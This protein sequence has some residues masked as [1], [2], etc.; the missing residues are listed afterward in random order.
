MLRPAPRSADHRDMRSALVIGTVLCA[1]ALAGPALAAPARVTPSPSVAALQVALRAQGHYV[2]PIDG[3]DGP[4]TQAALQSLRA[5]LGLARET[6]LGPRTRAA[7]GALGKPL[8]GQR[9]LLPGA[10]GWDV[11]SLEFQ[12]RPFGLPAREIDGRFTPA[13]AA[14]LRRFQAARGLAPDGIAG[15]RTFR[16][17]AT[18]AGAAA[19]KPSVRAVH[20]VAAGESFFSI[21]QRFAVSPLLLATENGLSLSSVILPGQRLRP[22]GREQGA[23]DGRPVAGVGA[24]RAARRPGCGQG[25]PRPL[26]GRLWRRP[27]P[28]PRGRV[29]GVGL[30]GGRGLG[31]RRDRRDA[32]P[33][34]RRGR[35]STRLIGV[36]TPRTYDGNVR[37]GRALPALAARRVRRR[38]PARP[39]R[40]L[41]GG[42]GRPPA[43]TLRGHEALRRAVRRLYGSV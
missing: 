18:R 13:T 26:V 3:L 28:L 11:A 24:C 17:L 19:P 25:L 6:R 12:L 43:R 31:R 37:A 5:R 10:V 29:D 15:K 40:L 2:A 7:L 21:A 20:V 36:R 32:A 22:S 8:L 27:A 4:L 39:R 38:S 35:G 30:P 23:A 1:L 9:E 42:G 14:A 41:P 16:A 33:A 34:G